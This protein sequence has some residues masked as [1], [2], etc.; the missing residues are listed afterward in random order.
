VTKKKKKGSLP[1]GRKK[2]S[3][4]NSE[5]KE[6]KRGRCRLGGAQDKKGTAHRKREKT[7]PGRGEIWSSR[8][9]DAQGQ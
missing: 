8:E 9:K 4:P 3:M 1:F 5:K 2:S 6:Q 7:W